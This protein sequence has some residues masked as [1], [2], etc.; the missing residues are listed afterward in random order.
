[1]LIRRLSCQ[2]HRSN[3]YVHKIFSHINCYSII[4]NRRLKSDSRFF[5]K[6]FKSLSINRR[7]LLM[8]DI[9]FIALSNLVISPSRWNRLKEILK[10]NN[11]DELLDH[12]SKD[13]SLYDK[14]M[15]LLK[16]YFGYE[17]DRAIKI[18]SKLNDE[19]IAFISFN[20]PDYP[21]TLKNYVLK[22]RVYRPLGL[23]VKPP[24]RLQRKYIAVVGT[25]KCSEWGREI[26][27][28]TGKIITSTGFTLVTGFAE[29]IDVSSMIGALESG[30][31]VVAVRPWLKPLILPRESEEILRRFK[32]RIVIISEHYEK[33]SVRSVETLYY[34]RN[35]II[36][37]IAELV[38]VIEARPEGGSMHQITWTIKQKKPLAIYRHPDPKSEY[39]RAFEKYSRYEQTIILENI[40][41]LKEYLKNISKSVL[42]NC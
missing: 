41:D 6:H 42:F 9:I 11:V 35:R 21:E 36:A 29:C 30:G 32:E 28:E 27:R 17:L 5:G 24:V 7:W 23:Y 12:M 34:L 39:Y 4:I 10:V 1:M 16:T 15:E 25:R 33:P 26:A 40:E 13:P 19:D 38:I 8:S 14:T 2:N 20:S 18:L 37:G 22:G 3:L 31:L